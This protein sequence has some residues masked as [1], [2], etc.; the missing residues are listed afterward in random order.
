[1]KIKYLQINKPCK[2]NWENMKDTGNGKFCEL[3]SKNVIDFSGLSQIEITNTLKFSKDVCAKITI[4]QAKEPL[5]NTSVQYD[6][7]FPYSR[8]IV[9]AS[10]AVS[11][12]LV[13]CQDSKN[14]EI[15]IQTNTSLQIDLNSKEQN[16][17]KL[18]KSN[19]LNSIKDKSVSESIFTG[20]IYSEKKSVPV[21]NAKV[22]LVTTYK[23]FT[24]YSLNDGSFILKIP[25]E[26]IDDENVIRVTYY[27]IEV[28]EKPDDHFYGFE[29][30]DFILSKSEMENDYTI[31]AKPIILTLGGIGFYE[32]NINPIVL[33]NGAEIKYSEFAKALAGKKSSCLLENKEYLYFESKEAM[34]I[35]GKKAKDGLYILTP[36]M[37]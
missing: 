7:N 22:M 21:K 15:P 16:N 11:T 2:E 31:K 28:T 25:T 1:M 9:A 12:T 14:N 27:N 24:T 29:N 30:A 32:E 37:D 10:L 4:Q 23:I 6:F 36:K 33:E 19:E 17:T 3:C 8:N 35:Y 5:I 34:A 18:N 20:K 26:L 13:S